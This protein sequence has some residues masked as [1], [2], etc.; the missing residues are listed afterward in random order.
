MTKEETLFYG[1][2]L[3]EILE[4]F[5]MQRIQEDELDFIQLHHRC[6]EWPN[7]PDWDRY[8]DIVIHGKDL[9]QF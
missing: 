2:Q 5:L 9:F 6:Q 3:A 7:N 8:E 4:E 1:E